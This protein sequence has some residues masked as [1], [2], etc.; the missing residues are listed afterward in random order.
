MNAA[1]TTTKDLLLIFLL[2][3]LLYLPWI[4]LPVTDADTAYYSIAAQRAVDSGDWMTLRSSGGNLLDKPPLSIWP[5]AVSYRL[6][7]RHDWSTRLWQVVLSLG[8][9]ALTYLVGRRFFGRREC[10]LATLILATSL[11]FSYCTM[12]VQQDILNLFTYALFFYVFVLFWQTHNPIAYYLA[13]L[14]LSLSFLNRWHIALVIPLGVVLACIIAAGILG[15]DDF[16]VK[17]LFG[18]WRSALWRTLLGLMIFAAI[19]G[20]WYIYEYMRLGRPFLDLFFG[21]RNLAF[22]QGPGGRPL[23]WL[24]VTYLPQLLLAVIPWVIFLPDGL[25]TGIKGLRLLRRVRT[26]E[27]DGFLFMSLWFLVAFLVPHVSAWRVIRYLLPVLPPLAILMAVGITRKLRE[28]RSFALS[29]AMSGAMMLIFLLINVYLLTQRL[30]AGLQPYKGLILPFSLTS[31][32]IF[33]AFILAMSWRRE[34]VAI[35]LFVMCT[36]ASYVAL[37]ASVSYK[38]DQ[39]SPWRSFGL[40]ARAMLRPGTQLAWYKADGRLPYGV[41]SEDEKVIYEYYV[42]RPVPFVG[43][44]GELGRMAAQGPTIIVMRDRTFLDL[45]AHRPEI[46]LQEIQAHSSGWMLVQAKIGE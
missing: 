38:W 35:V 41:P 30:D 19:G 39:V 6:W 14:A 10:L 17:N 15:R 1:K 29:A 33:A 12:V 22:L 43:Q 11:L 13:W 4:N 27:S 44:P 5:I 42:G 24:S 21:R 28:R 23:S 18:S 2:G 40:E 46:D 34:R 45:Q 16:R 36:V 8:T 37:F 26:R 25:A 7:G 3:A 31:M 32:I 20:T 9:L